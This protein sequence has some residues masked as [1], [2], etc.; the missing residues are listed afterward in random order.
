MATVNT[1][2]IQ[3]GRLLEVDLAAG[4]RTLH[5]VD[6]M[7]AQSAAQFATLDQRR[8]VVAA[9]WRACKL[10]TP[11]VAERALQLLV[12]VSP[13]IERAAILHRADQATSI[14]QVAR[15]ARECHFADRQVFTHADQMERWLGEVLDPPERARLHAFLERAG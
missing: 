5:D 3:V 2:R 10:F 1:C 7:I 4:Y 6:D 13:R 12:G 11:E 15:L 14:L 8:A 9:D